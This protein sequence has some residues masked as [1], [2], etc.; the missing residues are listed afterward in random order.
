M[1]FPNDIPVFGDIDYRGASPVE[2]AEQKTVFNWL[3]KNGY[4]TAIHPRNEG[5]KNRNQVAVE[6]AEG[7][8]TGASD[9]IIPGAPAFVCELKRTDHTKSSIEPEQIEYLRRCK[10]DG[11]FVCI[12]L[13]YKAVIEAIKAW[14]ELKKQSR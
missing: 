11:C 14:E 6:K 4:L 2:S 9:I 5:K 13:G 1:K 7:M 3:R 12:A 10:A 8:T